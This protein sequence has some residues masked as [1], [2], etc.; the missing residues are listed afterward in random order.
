[1]GAL[2]IAQISKASFKIL[3]CFKFKNCKFANQSRVLE[4]GKKI[5]FASDFHLGIPNRETSLEREKKIVAW[6]D[7]IKEEAEEIFLVG[8]IFDF[9][10][11]HVHTVP[12]GFVRLL[13]KL[14]ELSDT[15]IKITLFTG[16]HDMWMF[17]YLKKEL[18]VEIFR[19]P[20]ER[21]FNGKL[22]L[23]GHGDGLG[24]GDFWY[25]VLKW[26]CENK[27]C[28]WL[29][30]RLH[31]NFSFAFGH[32][33]SRKSRISTGKSDTEYLG[34]E[35]EFLVRFCKSALLKKQYDYFVFGH[36]HL[37]LE[38]QI[39]KSVY[40]NLGEWVNYCTFA[41]F[42]GKNLQMKFFDGEIKEWKKER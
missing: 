28:Q 12:K 13:G 2:G 19:V 20:I 9:W 25:K 26:I 33:C 16:N 42:D 29:F 30:A 23:I 32:Y 22:F 35:K 40:V 7:C 39:E 15:G 37:P 18:G 11:E 3:K 8:D 17:D 31:P 27:V 14:A 1:M 36:R 6:L 38:I 41:E 4:V 24:P 5:F 10:F 21:T 34:D